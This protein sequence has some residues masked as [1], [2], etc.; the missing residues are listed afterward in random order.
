MPPGTRL[1]HLASPRRDLVEEWNVR[2]RAPMPAARV[3]SWSPLD[4][5]PAAQPAAG[6][7]FATRN[8]MTL[9]ALIEA[10]SYRPYQMAAA[11]T[12]VDTIPCGAG[13][14]RSAGTRLSPHRGCRLAAR[15][16]PA[17]AASAGSTELAASGAS[18]RAAR[19]SGPG[20]AWPTASRA[21]DPRSFAG[22]RHKCPR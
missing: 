5:A 9:S 21:S 16:A 6:A 19:R 4:P 3:S 14:I 7:D 11:L 15:L 20:S 10:T 1:F 17:V 18:G 2:W 8:P 12:R 13:L 22:G